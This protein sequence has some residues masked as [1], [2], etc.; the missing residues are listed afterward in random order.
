M[1]VK[2]RRIDSERFYYLRYK[3]VLSTL[4]YFLELILLIINESIKY[5]IVLFIIEDYIMS[6]EKYLMNPYTGSIDT[7]ENWRSEMPFWEVSDHLS[8]EQADRVRLNQFNSLIEVTNK[9]GQ[10]VAI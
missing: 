5:F 7:E 3:I 9:S 4:K 1:A 8:K 6:K 10:W 2:P